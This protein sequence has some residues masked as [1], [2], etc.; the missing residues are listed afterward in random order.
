MSRP[1]KRSAFCLQDHLEMNLRIARNELD[2]N[3]DNA[4][5]QQLQWAKVHD[6][7]QRCAL[8]PTNKTC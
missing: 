5:K 6:A 1:R 2:G 8:S 3:K 4:T 7:R